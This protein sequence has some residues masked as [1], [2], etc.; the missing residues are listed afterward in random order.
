M[1]KSCKMAK[2]VNKIRRYW[3]TVWNGV[4]STRCANA[5]RKINN[6]INVIKI[7]SLPKCARLLLGQL[8]K[9]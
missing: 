2:T 7:T 8:G 3:T 4:H 1:D 5:L 9:S 6:V